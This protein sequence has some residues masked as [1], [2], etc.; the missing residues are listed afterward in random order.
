MV[1]PG[2]S[3]AL[4]H[5]CRDVASEVWIEALWA[6]VLLG[7]VA[8]IRHWLAMIADPTLDHVRR[9]NLLA[10]LHETC[11]DAPGGEDQLPTTFEIDRWWADVAPRF[12]SGACYRAGQPTTPG[13]LV[14][15]MIGGNVGTARHEFRAMSG[16]PSVQEMLG[17]VPMTPVERAA[18]SSWW[19]KRRHELPA[20]KLHRWGRSYEPNAVD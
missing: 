3:D 7:R 17:E 13:L 5:A 16:L 9:W 2:V 15:E 19:V 20:G 6:T 12:D 8:E 14:L 10:C 4:H 1:A 11:G 18:V